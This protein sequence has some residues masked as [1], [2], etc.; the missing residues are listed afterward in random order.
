MQKL[1]NAKN[2]FFHNKCVCALSHSQ[3]SF[4]I[5]FSFGCRTIEYIRKNQKS[6]TINFPNTYYFPILYFSLSKNVTD[7]SKSAILI[8]GSKDS[9]CGCFFHSKQPNSG[10]VGR[11]AGNT[12]A[13]LLHFLIVFCHA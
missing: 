1:Q 7:F 11:G 12:W 8:F 13:F 6:E 10:G 2:W 4:A 3:S 5:V 9:Y